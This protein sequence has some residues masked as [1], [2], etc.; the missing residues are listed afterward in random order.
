MNPESKD[1]EALCPDHNVT[2]MKQKKDNYKYI[3]RGGAPLRKALR[4]F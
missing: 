3:I 1:K 4:R 2:V